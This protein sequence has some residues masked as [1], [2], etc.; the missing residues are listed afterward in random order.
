MTC[1][2]FRHHTNYSRIQRG[3]TTYYIHRLICALTHNLPYAGDWVARH[4]CDNP[5]CVR[6]E[7][8]VPGTAQDNV[9]DCVT[10][11]RAKRVITLTDADVEAIR[12][13]TRRHWEIA[14]EYGVTRAHIS[15]IKRGDRR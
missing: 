7:H 6:V 8:I 15:N 13:D 9:L 1:V 10:R 12:A 3:Y 2:T 14:D 4:T 11:G 5:A